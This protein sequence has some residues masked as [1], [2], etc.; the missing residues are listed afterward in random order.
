[1][2]QYHE[3]G[4]RRRYQTMGDEAEAMFEAVAPLGP[5]FTEW[6][7]RRPPVKMTN[8]HDF[9]KHEP[10]FYVESGYGVECIGCGRDF[11]LKLKVT[12]YEALLFWD[13]LQQEVGGG[14][15]V[16]GWNSALSEWCLIS[17]EQIA[18]LIDGQE[19][20]AFND[21]NEYYPIEWSDIIGTVPYG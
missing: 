12:K 3:Q 18:R 5:R 21:G 6:G 8:M 9:I 4:W 10:D 19:P 1:M 11:V 7:W 15:Y 17:M 2:S 16:F 14:C 13:H 20:A